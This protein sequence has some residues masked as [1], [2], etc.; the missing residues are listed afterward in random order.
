MVAGK[1]I[2]GMTKSQFMKKMRSKLKSQPSKKQTPK[3]SD[4]RIEG[5]GAHSAR[6]PGSIGKTKTADRPRGGTTG[7][8][9]S[10]AQRAR[11]RQ[12]ATTAKGEPKTV[13]AKYDA[14]T[15]TVHNAVRGFLMVGKRADAKRALRASGVDISLDQYERI[16][17]K[18]SR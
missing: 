9:M 7:P 12:V 5:S 2:R 8:S 4:K 3:K 17:K 11:G 1:V 13:K 18:R 16:K 10:Q 14:L 15:K 6:P